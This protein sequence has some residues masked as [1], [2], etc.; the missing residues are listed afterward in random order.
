MQEGGAEISVVTAI[1]KHEIHHNSIEGRQ[2]EEG[3]KK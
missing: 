2:D 3:E 1:K